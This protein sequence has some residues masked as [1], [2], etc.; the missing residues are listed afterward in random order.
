LR[1]Q[2]W[3]FSSLAKYNYLVRFFFTER[4]LYYLYFPLLK[5]ILILEKKTLNNNI[6]IQLTELRLQLVIVKIY[7]TFLYFQ[8]KIRGKFLWTGVLS[9]KC[10]RH[11]IT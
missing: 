8:L 4:I 2:G 11:N 3:Q 7:N 5:N 9:P 1:I 6:F 10:H